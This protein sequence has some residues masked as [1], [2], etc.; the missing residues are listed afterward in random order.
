VIRLS[1]DYM[2]GEPFALFQ[3]AVRQDGGHDRDELGEAV[4][5]ALHGT[6]GAARSA[7]SVRVCRGRHVA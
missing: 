6:A 7:C 5:E 1:H 2:T 4:A 3:V